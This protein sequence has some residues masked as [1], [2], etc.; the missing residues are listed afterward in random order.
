MHEHKY[1]TISQAKVSCGGKSVSGSIYK[2]TK[3]V[4]KTVEDLEALRRISSHVN[5]NN[6]NGTNTFSYERCSQLKAEVISSLVTQFNSSD[7]KI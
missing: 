2:T 6:I 5:K 7:Y 4:L 3:Q 1:F